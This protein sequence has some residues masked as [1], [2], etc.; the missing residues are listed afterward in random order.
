MRGTFSLLSR[1]YLWAIP[2]LLGV[3]VGA[4]VV[5]VVVCRERSCAGSVSCVS[6]PTAPVPPPTTVYSCIPLFPFP[7]RSWPRLLLDGPMA[8]TGCG[9]QTTCPFCNNKEAFFLMV[10]LRSADE[11][12]T[13]FYKCTKCKQRWKE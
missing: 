2:P 11:P 5:V 8:G 3:K 4:I 10:Q 9:A 12:M 7:A 6:M 13:C 1:Q